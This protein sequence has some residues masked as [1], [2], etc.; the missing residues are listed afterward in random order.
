MCRAALIL[1]PNFVEIAVIWNLLRPAGTSSSPVSC[2]WSV[3]CQLPHK[4]LYCHPATATTEIST[5]LF[6]KRPQKEWLATR[7]VVL[8]SELQ[9]FFKIHYGTVRCSLFKLSEALPCMNR[10]KIV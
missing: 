7:K 10:S 3:G 6:L 8:S 5:N 1:K 2:I 4:Q 9:P